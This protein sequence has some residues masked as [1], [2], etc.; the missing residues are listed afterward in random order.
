[1]AHNCTDDTAAV[2]RRAGARVLVLDDG[3][4]GKAHAIAE[5]MRELPRPV[6]YVGVF[7]ADSRVDSAF[8]GVVAATIDGAECLQVETVPEL[9]EG[10]LAN[11]YGLGR[12]ARNAMWWRPREAL[13]MGVTISGTGWFITP[14]LHTELGPRLE[15]LTEDLELS[16]L[17]YSEGHRVLYTS[18]TAVTVQEPRTFDSSMSQRLRWIRG[19]VRVIGRYWPSLLRRGLSGDNGAFDMAVY[20]VAP[21]RMLTRT[22]ISIGLMLRFAGAPKAAS[23][24]LL[25][26]GVLS[27]FGVPALVGG[28]ANLVP[29][30]LTG[31]LLAVRHTLL[32]LLW[33][34]LGFWGLLTA[35]NESWTA[36]PRKESD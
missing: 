11:G 28:R 29:M 31:A 27:E 7:D 26:L 5:G 14:S 33:F 6:D 36:M 4:P 21:T 1:M 10:W 24:P 3:R 32:S 19:H 20:L 35:R 18:D 16:I 2:A 34:P 13:D 9:S 17:M 30:N 23:W 8:L 25:A 22:G 15:T 12:R